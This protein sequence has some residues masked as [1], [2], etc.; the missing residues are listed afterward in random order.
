M[1]VK[2]NSNY[3]DYARK[4]QGPTRLLEMNMKI[5]TKEAKNFLRKGYLK[6]SRR[7]VLTG[8]EDKA[9]RLGDAENSSS[10]YQCQI[11]SRDRVLSE[12]EKNSFIALPGKQGYSGF[13][14][15]T[16]K[17]CVPTGRIW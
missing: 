9:S 16:P 14:P 10:V 2:K 6:G 13:M 15:P 7:N 1:P 4:T 12:V 8:K 3:T 17:L 11:E 5:Q